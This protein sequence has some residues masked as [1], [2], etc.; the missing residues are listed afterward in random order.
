M[1]KSDYLC[2]FLTLAC[3]TFSSSAIAKEPKPQ[4][5]DPSYVCYK[6]SAKA[7]RHGEHQ[8]EQ[9]VKDRPALGACLKE[10]GATWSWLVHQFAGEGIGHKIYW[11]KNYPAHELVSD[12]DEMENTQR[13]I[14]RFRPD[15]NGKNNKG[16]LQ[17]TCVV[18]ELLNVRNYREC[19]QLFNQGDVGKL[20]KK[21]WIERFANLSFRTLVATRSFYFAK[22][23]PEMRK[24]SID[25]HP[26]FWRADMPK[27]F[28]EWLKSDDSTFYLSIGE[29]AYR[30]FRKS[31]KANTSKRL[32]SSR[33]SIRAQS[34]C[35]RQPASDR[36]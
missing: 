17:L 3:L 2:L 20:S 1:S 24:L 29:K 9:M 31:Q 7:L 11:D 23:A 12:Y 13:A 10:G 30:D 25:T 36:A 22:Y 32:S 14:I 34:H 21:E 28:S 33:Y 15:E 19:A 4:R 8:V 35:D 6:V 27:T 16:E 18:F 5:L 26:A